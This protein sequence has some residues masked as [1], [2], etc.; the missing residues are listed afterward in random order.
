MSQRINLSISFIALMMFATTLSA[1][2]VR[3]KDLA[4]IRG[5]RTNQLIGFGLVVGLPGT[6]DSAASI[7]K[8]RAMANLMNRLGMTL[9]PEEASVA[10][11][12][13]VVITGDLPAFARIGDRIDIKVASVGD[14]KSLVGGTLISSPIKAG[15]GKVYAVASGNLA[16]SQAGKA[17]IL[18][19]G[20]VPSGAVV[21]REFMPEVS[22]D[23]VIILS[24]KQPDYT[25]SARVADAIN[26]S[27][28]GF[29]ASARNPVSIEVNLPPLYTDRATEFIADMEGITVEVDQKATVV[30][31]E[32]SGTVVMGAEV[33]IAKVAIA[34]GDLSIQIGGKDAKKDLEQPKRVVNIG[35]ATVGELVESLNALGV[36]PNDLVAIIQSIHA[37]GALRADLKLM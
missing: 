23:G 2:S 22:N 18:T 20:M 8:N 31:N 21:E 26:A 4:N 27:F 35:G 32:R 19:T 14:A 7:S 6:G 13:S 9:T 15:D 11:V 1:Q 16:V 24:L 34:H 30:L 3:I 5:N 25:T 10:S 29:Y 33:Q 28:K 37:A 36:R 17:S 12:A